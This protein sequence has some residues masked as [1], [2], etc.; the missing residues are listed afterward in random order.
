MQP[1]ARYVSV[2]VIALLAVLT[3]LAAAPGG[4]SA[5]TGEAADPE[6][7]TT[8]LHPG[9]N[10]VGWLGPETP[11]VELFEAIPALQRVS[12]WDAVSQRYQSRTRTTIPRYALR[13]LEPGMGLW[14]KLGGD[15]PFEWTRP[16]VAGGVLVSLRPGG[17]WWA[18]RAPTARESRRRSSASVRPWCAPHVGRDIAGV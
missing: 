11:A 15:E 1:A 4:A 9:W 18:G 6:T 16:V 8:I 14:L 2:S 17:T 7:V 12:A 13:N 5:E 3:V 10:M